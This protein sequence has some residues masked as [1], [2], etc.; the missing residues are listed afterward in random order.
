[1][2]LEPITET[3]FYL[4]GA[5]NIGVIA[6]GN[7]GAIAIDT[8]LNK[9][10][11][12]HLR[13][14]L[15][16][17]GLHLRAIIST[18]HHADHIGGNA[19]LLRVAPETRMYAPP[20]EATLIEYPILEPVYLHLGAT[21]H[22]ALRNRWLMAE[23][24]PVHHIIGNLEAIEKGTSLSLQIADITLEILPLPGHSIA[25]IGVV[26]DNVCFATDGYFGQTVLE[27]Y[28]VP[29]AHNV[30]AQLASLQRL[31]ERQ[32]AWFL[33]GHG[34]LTPRATLDELLA[35]N[36]STIQRSTE[37]VLQ[38]LPGDI[39]TVT[40]RVLQELEQQDA[41]GSRPA[42]GA[43]QYAIFT[44]AIAAHLSYLEEQRQATVTY[45]DHGLYW[46]R[47]ES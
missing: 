18:H 2:K 43:P 30:A 28:G 29:Y 35:I 1:M 22:T 3:T 10:T 38:A 40:A 32:E 25:Q 27:K 8:G 11:A 14:G 23:G 16:E 34:E 6:T 37:Q 5:N 36:H 19:Y 4:P 41:A 13:K 39:A 15:D 9:D 47:T 24:A 44:S 20:L 12:R 46:E 7:G 42:M 45:Q 21:P 33:P 17:R 31:A 26:F